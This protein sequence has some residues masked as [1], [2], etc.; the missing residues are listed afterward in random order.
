V[1]RLTILCRWPATVARQVTCAYRN[2]CIGGDHQSLLHPYWRHKSFSAS[3]GMHRDTDTC[4]RRGSKQRG[5][6]EPIGS[7]NLF[8]GFDRASGPPVPYAEANV[9]QEWAAAA[10]GVPNGN[11]VHIQVR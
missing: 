3:F 5:C 11:A 10:P 8:C 9:P 7:P 2:V 1:Q 4:S 6:S